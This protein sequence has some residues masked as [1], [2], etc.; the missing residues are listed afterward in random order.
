MYY[1]F[2]YFKVNVIIGLDLILRFGRTILTC[3]SRKPYK[4][5]PQW[6]RFMNTTKYYYYMNGNYNN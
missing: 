2:N 3:C 1:Y 5:H 6:S 4:R